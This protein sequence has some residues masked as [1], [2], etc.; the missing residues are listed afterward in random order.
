MASVFHEVDARGQRAGGAGAELLP[1]GLRQTPGAKRAI[2]E[3]EEAREGSTAISP[4]QE[5]RE[6]HLHH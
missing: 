3:S 5:L 2:R 6:A 1:A 4:K